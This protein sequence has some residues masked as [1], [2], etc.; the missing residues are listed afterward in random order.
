MRNLIVGCCGEVRV[1]LQGA[2]ACAGLEFD[3]AHK[4][5]NAISAACGNRYAI[6][7]LS[8]DTASGA[9]RSLEKAVRLEWD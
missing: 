5:D 4:M 7:L 9:I 6:I 8:S 1:A 2:V 3:C